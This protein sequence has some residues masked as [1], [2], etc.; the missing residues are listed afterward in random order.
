MRGDIP[1]LPAAAGVRW[2]YPERRRRRGG[3]G[4]GQPRRQLRGRFHT[5]EV[6]SLLEKY[7]NK[8]KL[9]KKRRENS[10]R[11]IF[12]RIRI[13]LRIPRISVFLFFVFLRGGT[14]VEYSPYW[15]FLLSDFVSPPKIRVHC[16]AR[17]LP[18]IQNKN[19]LFSKTCGSGKIV[20]SPEITY[21]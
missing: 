8:I 18:H 3:E 10:W 21:L 16:P 4:G 14:C 15:F 19:R 5:L 11:I 6:R 20:K 7:R 13:R 2:L 1:S 17:L 9:T 12:L